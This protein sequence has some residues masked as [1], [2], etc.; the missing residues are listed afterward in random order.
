MGGAFSIAQGGRGPGGPGAAA[1]FFLRSGA[2]APPG[3]GF[4]RAGG[5][6]L[7]WAGLLFPLRSCARVAEDGVFCLLYVAFL[8]T[9][10]LTV[11]LVLF[12]HSRSSCG[13]CRAFTVETLLRSP[14]VSFREVQ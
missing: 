13:H 8:D 9:A 10:E 12:R 3:R 7:P 14:S 11:L 5:L 1:P 6:P 2:R 4:G